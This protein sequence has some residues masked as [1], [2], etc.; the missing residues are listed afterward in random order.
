ML[1]YSTLLFLLIFGV[2]HF[3][4]RKKTILKGWYYFFVFLFFTLMTG[5]R[6]R[7]GGDALAYEEYFYAFPDLDSYFS[8]M[9]KGNISFGY[10]PLFVLFVAICKSINPD[11]YFYQFIHAVV[12]NIVLFW[13]IRKNTKF[14]FS[15]ILILY[16]FLFYFYFTFD[17]QREILAVCCFLLGYKYFAKN[18][19]F[20]YYLFATIAFFFHI[21]AFFLMLLP[22]FKLIKLTRIFVV[23][24]IIVSIPLI[25]GKVFF[26][27]YLELILFTE[28]MQSKG[29]AYS[30]VEFSISGVI[31]YYT[32]RVLTLIPF[33][34]Y[35]SKNK[36]EE[37]NYDWLLT[38][39]FIVSILSQVMVGSDR[40]NNYLYIP[41]VLF[42]VNFMFNKKYYFRTGIFKKT[43]I[44]TVYLF[45]F[46][47]TGIKLLVGNFK[48][49]YYYNV[50][51]PYSSILDK[52]ENPDR[53][54]FMYYLWKQ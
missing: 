21:S 36:F 26:L 12:T 3:D 50:F 22:F 33:L 41:F 17:I 7:V 23:L 43:L 19:W 9:K 32:I 13:F 15:T 10:Q 49:Y 34:F 52:E 8:F 6:Y 35:Y 47:V 46:S 27:E 16:L 40:F 39:I 37:K 1:V 28:A 54:K 18:K 45:L 53:E 38:A 5:L 11:Y 51:F 20:F 25:I 14:E 29:E 42:F 44:F 24:T 2:F 30:K 4:Y 31:F 48:N